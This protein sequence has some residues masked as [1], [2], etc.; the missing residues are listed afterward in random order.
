MIR[1]PVERLEDALAFAQCAIASA[2]N[3]TRASSHFDSVEFAATLFNLAMIGEA[4]NA[5][6]DEVRTLVPEIRW[7]GLRGM[8]NHIIPSSHVGRRCGPYSA[9]LARRS[10]GWLKP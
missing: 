6:P 5:V 7:A 1:T 10:L 9:G 3:V 8:R 2:R 4:L